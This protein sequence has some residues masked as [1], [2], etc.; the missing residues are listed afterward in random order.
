MAVLYPSIDA[1][2]EKADSKY[3]LVVMAARRAR[4][5]QSGAERKSTVETNKNVTVALN[6]INDDLIKF[7]HTK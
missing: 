7:S 3:Y 2:T 6:E 5:L 1:L 4:Q